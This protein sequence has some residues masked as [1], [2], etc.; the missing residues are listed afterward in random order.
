MRAFFLLLVTFIV[1]SFVPNLEP[2]KIILHLL[3]ARRITTLSPLYH[4]LVISTEHQTS[5][6]ELPLMAPK[7]Y[8]YEYFTANDGMCRLSYCL[9][10]NLGSYR[11][12]ASSCALGS[13]RKK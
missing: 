3:G 5:H 11:W 2:P 13:S 12:I 9:Q 1:F 4:H 10:G 7:K 6:R 8:I